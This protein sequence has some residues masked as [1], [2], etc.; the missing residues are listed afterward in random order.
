M[1]WSGRLNRCWRVRERGRTQRS[2]SWAVFCQPD[3][4]A[5]LGHERIPELCTVSA[6]YHIPGLAG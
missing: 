6:I 3:S 5:S 4:I 2:S 1:H